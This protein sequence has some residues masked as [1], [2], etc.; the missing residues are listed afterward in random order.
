MTGNKNRSTCKGKN[1]SPYK[2]KLRSTM[3]SVESSSINDFLYQAPSVIILIIMSI[4]M[5]TPITIKSSL[6]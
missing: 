5:E 6:F 1:I 4:M 3:T 2:P